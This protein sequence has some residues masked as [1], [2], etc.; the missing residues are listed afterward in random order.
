MTENSKY[1][2]DYYENGISSGISLYTNYRWIPELTIPMA[3]TLID[4]FDLTRDDKILDYGCAKGFLVKAFRLLH[5][6]AWGVDISKYAIQSVESEAKPYCFLCNNGFSAVF[7]GQQGMFPYY[8][9][10]CIAKDV[11]EHIP[12]E[13]LRKV[14]TDL[15]VVKLFVVVPL[16]DGEKFHI[17]LFEMDNTHIHRQPMLWWMDVFIDT[18]WQCMR[19]TTSFPGIK[20]AWDTHENGHG[21]FVLER[22]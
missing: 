16:G 18:G 13:E 10:F 20:D 3:M 21:F 1:N 4:E 19:S 7:Y 14:L 5:R 12:L 22:R 17:P 2:S 11:F 15:P 9:D 6:K 8:F